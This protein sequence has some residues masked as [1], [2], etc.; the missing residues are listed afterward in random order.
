MALTEK[1]DV[2]EVSNILEP[3]E[4]A[5]ISLPSAACSVE[6]M[7]LTTSSDHKI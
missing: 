1:E 3:R 5:M 7:C 4:I 6:S 2:A